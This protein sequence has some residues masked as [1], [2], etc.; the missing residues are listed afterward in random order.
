MPASN[1]QDRVTIIG[2][3]E[4]PPHL[5]KEVFEAKMGALL[6]AFMALP[7]CKKNVL[8]WDLI[9][10]MPSLFDASIRAIGFSEPQPHVLTIAECETTDHWAE[11]GGSGDP[12]WSRLVMEGE[13]EFGFCSS[14][15][16]FFTD[17]VTK[18][19]GI[20][21]VN[22]VRSVWILKA[23]SRFSREEFSHKLGGFVDRLLAMPNSQKTFQK[24]VMSQEDVIELCTD[25]TVKELMKEAT[26]KLELH[27][28]SVAFLGDLQSKGNRA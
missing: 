19:E 15:Q 13:K 3:R 24:H 28:N 8:K 7:V 22:P 27:V 4:V 20:E 1:S 5:S 9:V 14:S 18:I 16:T 25:Q 10:P 26:A 12:E 17:V 6:D 23:Q 2:V 21:S 11:V